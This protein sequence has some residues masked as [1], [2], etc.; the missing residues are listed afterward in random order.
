MLVK[1]PTII[2]EVLLYLKYKHQ[3]S[4]LERKTIKEKLLKKCNKIIGEDS[5]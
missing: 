1:Q 3:Y 4:E 5:D 2:E